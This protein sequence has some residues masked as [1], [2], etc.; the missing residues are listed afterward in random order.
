MCISQSLHSSLF[1]VTTK[2]DALFFYIDKVIVEQIIAKASQL[3]EQSEVS[4]V[5]YANTLMR[6]VPAL[7]TKL[8]EL[9]QKLD[10][11]PV[12]RHAAKRSPKV[13]SLI[14]LMQ[15]V[16]QGEDSGYRGI[17]FV[18]QVA[19]VSSLAKTLN[20][21]LPSLNLRCGAV[22]GTGYQ[23]DR[24]RQTQLDQFKSGEIRILAA[25]ATLEEGIDVSE[26][27]FVVR[28]TSVATTKAHIQGAGRARHPNA[29]I[30][31]FEN[32]PRAERQK[33]AA[34]TATA[35]DMSLSLTTD[36]LQDAIGS[37]AMPFDQ[38][39]P[40]PFRGRGTFVNDA[41]G[42]ANVFNSKQ[43]FNQYCSITL[44]ASLQ[45]KKDLYQYSHKPGEQ[46][47]LSKIRFPTPNGWR[48]LCYA[49]YQSF[50][51]STDIDQVV[52]AERSKKKSS[53]EKEEMC[54]VYMVVVLL[55]EQGYL[56]SHN[57]PDSAIRSDAKRTCPLSAGWLNAIAIKNT[58]FQSYI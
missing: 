10:A 49:D 58:V 17:V 3:K 7:R 56:D 25:T 6:R 43:I 26:C 48:R 18:E 54:F 40:Y 2:I 31:Y 52:A 53:S 57:R 51:G 47:I 12:V 36:A 45:P 35:K 29:V 38:R 28:Y 20:D 16:F 24:D 34:L 19:L 30:Y 37:I 4:T 42:E 46:K 9:R 1:N 22:A 15:K 8:D 27:A 44:G 55:R 39:H 50:W 5:R 41:S 23:S 32:N 33:E 14:D 13:N 21:S 11:D